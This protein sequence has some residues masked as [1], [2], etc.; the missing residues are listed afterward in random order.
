MRQ[1]GGLVVADGKP[2]VREPTQV[3]AL[4]QPIAKLAAQLDRRRPGRDSRP[5]AVRDGHFCGPRIKQTRPPH[6]IRVHAR[7]PGGRENDS[8]MMKRLIAGL[9]TTVLVS[10]G[11]GAA[12]FGLG[13]GSAQAVPGFAPLA[14]WCPGDPV[15][16]LPSGFDPGVCHDYYLTG[17][18]AQHPYSHPVEGVMPPPNIGQQCQ[19][20]PICLPGL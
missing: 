1:A 12:G 9:S 15:Q 13:A 6:R 17:P 16:Q 3:I 2:H 8:G 10:A 7:L 4:A 5:S 19:G 14:R 11:V 18:D 20:S